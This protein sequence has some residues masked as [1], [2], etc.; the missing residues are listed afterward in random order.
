MRHADPID[1]AVD[2][3]EKELAA[4]IEAQRLAFLSEHYRRA[5]APRGHCLNPDCL[6]EFGEDD[7]RL[8]CGP[9]CEQVHAKMLKR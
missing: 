5:P 4:A 2:H 1:G 6:V 7:R 8:F 9:P 3:Q